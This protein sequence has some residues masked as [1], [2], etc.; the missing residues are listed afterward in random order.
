MVLVFVRNQRLQLF[1]GAIFFYFQQMEMVKH[2]YVSVLTVQVRI[3]P[4]SNCF[5]YSA[6]LT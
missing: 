2:Y 1:K 4:I 5:F 3:A 6:C